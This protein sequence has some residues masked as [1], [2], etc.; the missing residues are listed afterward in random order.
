MRVVGG[1]AVA[2]CGFPYAQWMNQRFAIRK[3][4]TFCFAETTLNLQKGR[5][6][7][8]DLSIDTPRVSIFFLMVPTQRHAIPFTLSS[9]TKKSDPMDPVVTPDVSQFEPAN[10]YRVLA[11]DALVQT[12][13]IAFRDKDRMHLRDLIDVEI[14]DGSWP[15]RFPPALADRLQSLLDTPN[16]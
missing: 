9:R 12:K 15:A 1:N 10:G 14:I 11:L 13:L 7:L 8:R 3:T 16:G 4:W 6:K 5:W 2:C